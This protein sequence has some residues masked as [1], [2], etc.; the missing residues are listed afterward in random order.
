M[1]ELCPICGSELKHKV[2]HHP[3]MGSYDGVEC[4]NN[5]DLLNYFR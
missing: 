5:C 4:P 3:E 1:V 2:G